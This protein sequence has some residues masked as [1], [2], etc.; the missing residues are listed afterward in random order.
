MDPGNVNGGMDTKAMQELVQN[1]QKVAEHIKTM[2][3]AFE[4]STRYAKDLSGTMKVVQESVKTAMDGVTKIGEEEE[5]SE[6]KAKEKLRSS[7]AV[8]RAVVEHIAPLKELTVLQEQMVESANKILAAE[9]KMAEVRAASAIRSEKELSDAAKRKKMLE[10]EAGLFASIKTK[11]EEM[12]RTKANA[13]YDYDPETGEAKRKSGSAAFEKGKNT[14]GELASGATGLIGGNGITSMLSQLGPVGALLGFMIAGKMEDMK[15]DAIG[16]AVKQQFDRIGGA[17]TEFGA[18]MASTARELSAAS[19]AGERDLEAVAKSF[20]EAGISAGKVD[21][22]ITGLTATVRGIPI[23]NMMTVTLG[24]DKALEMTAGSM[25]KLVGQAGQLASMKPEQGLAAL[26]NAGI[27]A[28]DAGADMVSFMQQTLEASS[29]LKMFNADIGGV[30]ALSG[31]MFGKMVEGKKFE[32]PFAQNYAAS[33]AASVAQGIAGMDLGMQAYIGEKV[34]KGKQGLDAAYQFRSAAARDGEQLPIA[35]IVK[36]MS[37]FAKEKGGDS[38]AKQF[39][40]LQEVFKLNAAG[41]DAIMK[42]A[43][44]MEKNGGTLDPRVAELAKRGLEDEASK[45]DAMQRNIKDI[46]D[47]LANIASGMLGIIVN[48]LKGIAHGILSLS[49]S[50]NPFSSNEDKAAFSKMASAEMGQAFKSVERIGK[51]VKQAFGGATGLLGNVL[52]TGN[53]PANP[54][55]E[56]WSILK[57]LS[58]SD[59]DRLADGDA[60]IDE[61]R[62]KLYGNVNAQPNGFATMA[63]PNVQPEHPQAQGG[64]AAAKARQA[65]AAPA[66]GAN[67]T[68]VTAP[69]GVQVAVEVK[70]NP[71]QANRSFDPASVVRF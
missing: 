21:A 54:N 4:A 70:P 41:A 45:T 26:A 47:G 19:M 11:M 37:K 32:T 65:G 55:D 63:E 25:A 60:T 39:M 31:A 13:Q 8:A 42:A 50:L 33:G 67:K 57:K 23:N 48:L 43:K 7:T 24:L 6:K 9:S 22:Q 64:G 16:S 38:E 10:D 17:T 66:Q 29:A 51:G 30:A 15:F 28:K 27:K 36:E 34:F 62:K 20:A 40:I 53:L 5:K 68:T 2:M 61:Y 71:D 58:Q 3:G 35:D 59:I 49:V 46:R 12:Q 56:E 52:G 1:M 18:K 69:S 44:D 14:I